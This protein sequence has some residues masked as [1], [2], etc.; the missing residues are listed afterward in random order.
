MSFSLWNSLAEMETEMWRS[1]TRLAPYAGT[2]RVL[3]AA[4]HARCR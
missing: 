3:Y 1:E 2:T 4:D